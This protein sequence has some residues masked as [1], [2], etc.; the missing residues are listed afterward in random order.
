MADLF[1]L[2]RDLRPEHVPQSK[3]PAIWWLKKN[4]APRNRI[5]TREIIGYVTH[6]PMKGHGERQ[7]KKRPPTPIVYLAWRERSRYTT[8]MLRE[9]RR[10]HR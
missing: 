7:G 4:G 2:A 6:A 3:A 10:T 1:G 5:R 9:I 8:T